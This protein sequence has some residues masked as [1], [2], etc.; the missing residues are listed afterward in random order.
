[1]NDFGPVSWNE[2]RRGAGVQLRIIGALMFREMRTRFGEMQFGYA[3]AI[4]EPL[5]QIAILVIV[6]SL[7]GKR[8]PL[9]TSFEAFFLNG[10]V[11]YALFAQI[12]G[13]AALA[14]S[15][16]RALLSFPPVRNMDTVWARILLETATGMT[17]LIVLAALFAYFNVP[18]IPNDPIQYIGGFLSVIVL[19]SGFG[20]LNAAL[21]PIF[22]WW[23]M[24][25]SWFSKFQY[26]FCGIFFIPDFLPPSARVF[27]S[28]NPVAHCI[29]WIRE[30]FYSG[31][32]SI[33][34]DKYFPFACAFVLAILGLVIERVFRRRVDER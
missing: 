27:V 6:F 32:N 20:I 33:V 5:V 10:Y 11:P 25:F 13:R 30:G 23:M 8:P 29:I 31:Y 17:S 18:V 4:I 12:S 28:L 34:L 19:A 7:L 22:K 16:N 14:I 26:F 15:S 1:M 3:W 24:I 2:V 9:G 21:S